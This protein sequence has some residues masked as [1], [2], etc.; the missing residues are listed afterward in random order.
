M[1]L[2]RDTNTQANTFTTVTPFTF[3][4]AGA[5]SK[6]RAVMVMIQH[7]AVSTDL[8]GVNSVSY[9]N[10]IMTRVARGVDSV[11]EAGAAY[12]YF[13]GTGI[14][15][16][17]QTV[18]IAHTGSSDVKVAACV[19]FFGN[20]DTYV[21]DNQTINANQANPQVTL[22]TGARPSIAIANIYSGLLDTNSLSPIASMTNIGSGCD[23]GAFMS[24]QAVEIVPIAGPR[25]VGFIGGTD[26]VGMAA[27]AIAEIWEPV[28]PTSQ[29]IESGGMVGLRTV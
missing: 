14:P 9:G 10:V 7:G 19:S 16:G 6:V 27:S 12:N 24:K 26:D 23:F 28:G 1:A 29:L 22:D 25:L 11:T 21:Y 18:S 20:T 5:A 13:L 8:I 15:Q 2:I 17:S 3:S 4:H